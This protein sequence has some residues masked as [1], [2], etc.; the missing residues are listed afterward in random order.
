[1]AL[2]FKQTSHSLPR[3]RKR[4]SLARRLP[5][6]TQGLQPAAHNPIYYCLGGNSGARITRTTR[7]SRSSTRSAPQSASV[8]RRSSRPTQWQLWLYRTPASSL[9]VSQSLIG[10]PPWSEHMLPAWSPPENPPARARPDLQACAAFRIVTR[11]CGSV[12]RSALTQL[13]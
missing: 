5:T 12:G 1:M 7:T 2:F 11:Q 9:S 6:R 4:S 10:D 13:M 3:T 8:V